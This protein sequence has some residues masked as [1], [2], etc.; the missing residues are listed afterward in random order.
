[1]GSSYTNLQLRDALVAMDKSGDW[2][3]L[4][5]IESALGLHFEED[6]KAWLDQY[7]LKPREPVMGSAWHAAAW[8]GC[9]EM[10]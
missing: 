5:V 4:R 9:T 2:D 7:V 1:V 8:K 10:G 3:K 6:I